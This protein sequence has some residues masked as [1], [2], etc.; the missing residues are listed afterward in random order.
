MNSHQPHIELWDVDEAAHIKDARVSLKEELLNL[1]T[2][3]NTRPA[4]RGFNSHYKFL[5][6]IWAV[7]DS[8]SYS[9]GS[10]EYESRHRIH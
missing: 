8:H 1:L 9:L 6:F 7:H 5:P 10:P 3:N 2:I 4:R